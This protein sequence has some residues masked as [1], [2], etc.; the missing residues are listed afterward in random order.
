MGLRT[1]P[2]RMMPLFASGMHNQSFDQH[3]SF[4]RS[5]AFSSDALQI[6]S[7]SK[8]HKVVDTWSP[9]DACGKLIS[10]TKTT[11][12]GTSTVL[13]PFVLTP[14]GWVVDISFDSR[15]PSFPPTSLSWQWRRQLHPTDHLSLQQ[16]IGLSLL[17]ISGR[18]PRWMQILHFNIISFPEL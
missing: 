11:S 18:I 5:I 17:C 3:S 8:L 1:S 15:C 13:N 7:T 16:T 9:T 6:F 2:A 10:K 4:I 12:R 14:D